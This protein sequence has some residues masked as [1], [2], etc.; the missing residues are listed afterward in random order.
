MQELTAFQRDILYV[1]AGLDRPNGL[2]I[3]ERLENDGLYDRVRH[4]RIYPNLESIRQTGLIEKG[5]LT[6]R[7]NWHA[8]TDEGWV[9]LV[10]RREWENSV[11]PRLET[12]TRGP[13]DD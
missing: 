12:R 5:Q 9:A 11:I 10:D 7:A 6:D 4:G 8:L 3:G 1:I 13:F 2:E